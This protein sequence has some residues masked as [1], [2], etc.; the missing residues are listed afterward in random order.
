MGV[1]SAARKFMGLDNQRAPNTDKMVNLVEKFYKQREKSVLE[2]YHR[3][4]FYN[5]AMRRGHQWIRP[6]TTTNEILP[7]PEDENRV[8]MKINEMLGIHTL[9]VAKLT[10]ENPVWT[11]SVDIEDEDAKEIARNNELLLKY[12]FTRE[13]IELQRLKLLGWAVDT[14][15]AFWKIIWDHEAGDTLSDP[16]SGE[17][18]SQGDVKFILVPPFDITFSWNTKEKMEDADWVLHSHE[19]SLSTIR[20]EWPNTGEMV[21]AERDNSQISFY[22]KKLLALVGNQSDYYGSQDTLDKETAVVKEWYAKPCKKYPEGAYIAIANGVWLNPTESGETPPLPYQHLRNDREMPYP[23]VHMV[24]LL[25]S[26]SPWG[27]G[28][29]ENCIEPQKGKNR[30]FSQIIENSNNFGNI[31]VLAPKGAELQSEAFDDS[32]NEVIEYNDTNGTA[33][34]YLTPTSL[35]NYVIEQVNMF[36][37][38]LMSIGQYEAASRGEVPS[39]VRSGVAIARLQDADDSRVNPTMIAYRSALRKAG[40][41]VLNLYREFMLDDEERVVKI[42]GQNGV[43]S[44]IIS[45]QKLGG[46]FTIYVELESQAAWSREVRREQIQNAYQMGLIG[47]QNDPK[48]K[49]KVLEALEFGHLKQIFSDNN[50][51][52]SNAKENIERIDQGNLEIL[53][54]PQPTGTIDFSGN[55]ISTP[56]VMG[57]KANPW[58]DHAIHIQTYNNFRKGKRWRMWDPRKQQ[59]LNDLAEAHARFLNAPPPPVQP[60]V[61]LSG[62]IKDLPPEMF[63]KVTGIE[64]P[65]PPMPPTPMMGTHGGEEIGENPLTGA[66][67]NGAP[68]MM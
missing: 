66:P 40:K 5:I 18:V 33:P 27:I 39:G 34:T 68:P 60:K 24:D 59:I 61:S 22:Q 13:D 52:E 44:H 20:D 30:V 2:Q 6:S 7:P 23:F 14:G 37:K 10:K 31:K 41:H 45:K 51:D 17:S 67:E 63:S 29:M 38:A 11:V 47:D 58:E 50:L 49:Q 21:K 8:R 53:Q 9:K 43:D 12:A 15:N 54:P 3:Q 28:T 19:E 35:P 65:T 16:F 25:V 57:I 62:S 48:V 4:W 1:I 55:P 56:P 32:G 42:L 46:N 64:M 26:G 36:D